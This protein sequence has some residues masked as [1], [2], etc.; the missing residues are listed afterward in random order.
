[1]MA[2][3]T[4]LVIVIGFISYVVIYIHL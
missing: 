4:G 2:E 3:I 1:M